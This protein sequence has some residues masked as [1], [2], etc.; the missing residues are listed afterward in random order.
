MLRLIFQRFVAAILRL[1]AAAGI[2]LLLV[3]FSYCVLG[4]SDR[5][6]WQPESWVSSPLGLPA[7]AAASG[8][9]VLLALSAIWVFGY[10]WGILGARFRRL[11]G[12]RL[13]SAPFAFL[14]CAPGFWLV[15]LAAV[16]SYIVWQRPGFA[17]DLV[18]ERGPDLLAWWHAAVVAL[19][20][21]VAGISWQIRAVSATLEA[22]TAR[23]WVRGLFI[24][25]AG[26]EEIFYGSALR[27]ARPGLWALLDRTFPALAGSLLVLESAFRYP[28]LGALLVDSVRAASYP[29]ILAA[30]LVLG[31]AVVFLTFV[32]ELSSRLAS[33]ETE[34]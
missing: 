16:Y 13:L 25:G 17:N 11:G 6:L 12:G 32:R 3:E 28:G 14:A 29:G 19:P 1:A 33:L 26:D 18:V 23:P 21:A 22:E 24:G 31:V 27:H 5:H 15:I 10:A 20:A 2:V 9:V 4:G 34:R 7:S 30:S 8:K